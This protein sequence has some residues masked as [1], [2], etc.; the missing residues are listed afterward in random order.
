MDVVAEINGSMSTRELGGI[1]RHVAHY[2]EY[3]ST[4]GSIVS[5]S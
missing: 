2:E 1:L 3:V 5:V 4:Q